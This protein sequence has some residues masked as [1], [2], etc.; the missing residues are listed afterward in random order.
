MMQKFRH[1]NCDEARQG[2]LLCADVGPALTM[3]PRTLT[4]DSTAM[5]WFAVP[6]RIQL[7]I[8]EA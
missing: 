8:E 4:L 3:I 2:E 1:P 7:R 5:S 6:P